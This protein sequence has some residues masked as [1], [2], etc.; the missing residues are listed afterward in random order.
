MTSRP[1]STQQFAMSLLFKALGECPI[2]RTPEEYE[3]I[4]S[5][6]PKRLKVVHHLINERLREFAQSDEFVSWERCDFKAHDQIIHFEPYP[7]SISMET[8][9]QALIIFGWREPQA[10]RRLSL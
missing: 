7:K 2:N 6:I 5:R 1:T 9:R 10:R 4:K 8:V 3:E